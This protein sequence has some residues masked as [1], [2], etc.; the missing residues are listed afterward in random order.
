MSDPFQEKMD[1]LA[2]RG[3][4]ELDG[5]RGTVSYMRA[6]RRK[7]LVAYDEAG[8]AV[9]MFVFGWTVREIIVAAGP[10][11]PG[12]RHMGIVTYT[13]TSLWQ[14]ATVSLAGPFAERRYAP[15]SNW[16]KCMHNDVAEASKAIRKIHGRGKVGRDAWREAEMR[17]EQLLEEH[18]GKIERL[19][20]ALSRDV[21]VTKMSGEEMRSIIGRRLYYE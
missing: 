4:R 14:S 21:D 13:T 6:M 12:A 9:A 15:R 20:A 18:W 16:R 3:S 5:V 17:T 19:A 7:R 1:R 10:V 2:Q 11:S 8:H